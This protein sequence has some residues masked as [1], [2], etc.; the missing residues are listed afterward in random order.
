VTLENWLNFSV[1]LGPDV[2]S[3]S[4]FRFPHHCGIKDFRRFLSISN[5]A[6]SDL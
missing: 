6:L 2:D 5:T 3:E 1:D 4:H